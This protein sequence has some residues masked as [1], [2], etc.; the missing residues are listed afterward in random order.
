MVVASKRCFVCPEGLF[1]IFFFF[2]IAPWGLWDF[3]SPT[4]NGTLGVLATRLSGKSFFE[5][6]NCY[7]SPPWHCS[8]G[9]P[10]SILHQFS[11]WT[12]V[13]VQSHPTV[14]NPRDC[15]PSGSSVHG[16]FQARTLNWV[17]ISYSKRSFW[18]RDWTLI[19]C[20]SCIGLWILYYCHQLGS[21][22]T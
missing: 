22:W 2:P 21:P 20:V 15:S 16:I 9:E 1:E 7:L 6:L 14:C 3:S 5:V 4:R 19:S 18:P 11:L 12:Y 10:S 13:Y 8:W 17:A